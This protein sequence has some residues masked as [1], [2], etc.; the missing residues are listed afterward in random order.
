MKRY[1]SIVTS[2]GIA[3]AKAHIFKSEQGK[4]FRYY[5][6]KNQIESE[7]KRFEDAVEKVSKTILEQK[8]AS[9]SK[10]AQ[11]VLNT[12]LMMLRDAEFH[13]KVFDEIKKKLHNVEWAIYDVIQGYI[14]LLE[15]SEYQNLRDREYDLN[16]IVASL[17]TYLSG[18]QEKS[19]DLAEPCILVSQ[20]IF[21]ADLLKFPR[22][23]IMGIAV[24]L[25]GT[26]SHTSII[27]K[28]YGIPMLVGIPSLMSLVKDGETIVVDAEAG[29]LYTDLEEEEKQ[30]FYQEYLAESKRSQETIERASSTRHMTKDNVPV[31]FYVNLDVVAEMNSKIMDFSDGVGLLRTEFLFPSKTSLFSEEHQFLTYRKIL[32]AMKGK[33]V[34]IRTFDVGGDKT[35]EYMQSHFEKNPLMGFRGL[36]FSLNHKHLLLSQLRAILRA[37]NFGKIRVLVPMLSTLEEWERFLEYLN[38]VKN[39]LDAEGLGYDKNIKVGPMIEIPSLLYVLHDLDPLCDFWSIGTN[40]LLQFVMASDRTNSR[41]QYLYKHL[42]PAFLR[43][44]KYIFKTSHELKKDYSLCGEMASDYNAVPLLLGAGL[45]NYSVSV[46]RLPKLIALMVELRAEDSQQLFEAALK[47]KDVKGV[48]RTIQEF[49]SDLKVGKE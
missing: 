31:S 3:V 48:I 40:D 25:G 36:R 11:D 20:N 30:R 38:E 5:L 2:P 13:D 19:F 46:S 26:N 49:R 22:K 39:Q 33:P 34:T 16:E 42:Q 7:R 41:V 15:Y 17:I 14:T 29:C 24:E 44:L 27:A 4:I 37:S 21:S 8:N 10:N 6:R 9:R 45:R 32:E 12:Y 43:V 35:R 1:K 28:S 47:A 18:S 23:F